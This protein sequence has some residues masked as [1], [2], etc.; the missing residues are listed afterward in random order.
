AVG[1]EPAA[2][3]ASLLKAGSPLVSYTPRHRQPLS[4]AVLDLILRGLSVHGY[5]L[6]RWLSSTPQEAIVRTYRDLAALVANGT[7]AAPVEA[8][9][10]LA[11]YREAIGHAAQT[12]RHGKVLFTFQ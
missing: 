10:T 6:N 4:I 9:Y 1:G 7:L 2:K 8:T 3:L 11:E 5:W 12:D